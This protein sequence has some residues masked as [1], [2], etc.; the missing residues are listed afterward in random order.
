[1]YR[2]TLALL[3]LQV[4]MNSFVSYLC[5]MVQLLYMQRRI[6]VRAV[7]VN[8]KGQMFAVRQRKHDGGE[9]DFWCTIGGGVDMLETLQDAI[10]RECIEESGV[11][12]IVGPLLYVQQFSDAH[13]DHLEFFFRVE[14]WKDF[15]A[16]DLSKT[17]HGMA[18]IVECGFIDVQQL[19][20]LPTFLQEVDLSKNAAVQF[21]SY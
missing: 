1:M 18:E 6:A 19:K 16:V 17:T 7:I 21:F 13:T 9:K 2:N 3:I 5:H 10:V 15:T 14:N 4:V 12:P 8:D 20:T 11:T